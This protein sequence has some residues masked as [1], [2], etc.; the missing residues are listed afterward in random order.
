M[1]GTD[2]PKPEDDDLDLVTIRVPRGAAQLW[3]AEQRVSAAPT[4]FWPAAIL[5]IVV[6]FGVTFGGLGYALIG[7]GNLIGP[8][9]EW[10]AELIAGPPVFLVG[11]FFTNAYLRYV[12]EYRRVQKRDA[13]RAG[14]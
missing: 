7:L 5:L 3:E 2:M 8:R 1:K 6:C 4:V 10:S 11:L 12:H 9:G 13:E 14:K